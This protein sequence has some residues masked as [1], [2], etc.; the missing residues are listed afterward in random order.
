VTD[1]PFR[2]SHVVTVLSAISL[3][4]VLFHMQLS[5]RE[6]ANTGSRYATIES[7][8][9]YG[10]YNIDASRYVFTPDK[11]RARDH[12]VSSKPPLLPTYGA[13]VYWLIKKL[14]PYTILD[15]EG[16]V[17]FTVGLFTGWLGHLVFLVY[18][19][20]LTTLLLEKQ[21]SIIV[22]M[23]AACFAWLGVAYGTAINNHGPGA[24]LGVMG[25]YYVY[26]ARSDRG[27]T[28]DWLLGGFWLGV[29]PAIDL[30]SAAV[31]GLSALY[32]VTKDW[33]R[34]LLLYVPAA[35]P[36]MASQL[37]LAHKA[38]GTWIPAY[39][40]A[41]LMTYAGSY[42]GG[43]RSGIDALYEPKSVYAWN[44]LL[45]H[46]GLFSMTP[47]FFFSVYELVRRLVKRDRFFWEAAGFGATVFVVTAFYIVRTHNYGG[48]CVGM[49]WLVPVMPWLVMLFGMWL[50]RAT[51]SSFKW[52]LVLAAFA[53]SAFNVQDG[54]IS[55]FQFSLWH[56]FLDDAPNRNRLGPPTLVIGRSTPTPRKRPPRPPRPRPA[57]PA[58]P[59][60]AAP[61]VT[62]APVPAP[63]PSR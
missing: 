1:T 10:T 38:T 24:A 22:T 55:P 42:F 30:S 40:D 63:A 6:N 46:H 2:T 28:L 19:Y 14:T 11:V 43:R 26:C 48:W 51:L 8:V 62:V 41:S 52:A 39:A 45:G 25:F 12:F 13:G 53:V 32:L 15:N 18:F 35:L 60:V 61:P 16:I 34:T 17:V 7:L 23:A 59:V 54:L 21:L 47:L 31:T 37:L 5:S 29:L 50:D 58:A 57:A 20:R 27:R 9:D 56:N 33:K 36:G 3:A 4:M 49:R 44:V